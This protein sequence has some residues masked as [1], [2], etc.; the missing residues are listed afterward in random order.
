MKQFSRPGGTNIRVKS[1][2]REQLLTRVFLVN[3]ELFGQW[4]VV[5][6]RFV[7]PYSDQTAKRATTM[8]SLF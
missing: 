8:S 4:I 2:F 6:F 1:I 5:E 3:H 7:T